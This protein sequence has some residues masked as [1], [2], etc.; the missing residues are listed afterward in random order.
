MQLAHKITELEP[1]KVAPYLATQLRYGHIEAV[2]GLFPGIFEQLPDYRDQLEKVHAAALKKE[3]LLAQTQPTELDVSQTNCPSCGAVLHRARQDA[4]A[5]AC[6][7]CGVRFEIDDPDGTKTKVCDPARNPPR[8]FIRLGMIAKFDG[9]PFQVVGRSKYSGKCREWDS[10]DNTWESTPWHFEEWMLLGDDRS[11]RYLCHDKEGMTLSKEFKPTKP[12]LP[13]PND[14]TMTLI[15]GKSQSKIEEHGSYRLTYFE[16]EF[17]WTPERGEG[18]RTAEYKEKKTLL[19]AEAR[20]N[21]ETGQP[22]EI[23]FFQ[24]R[25]LQVKEVLTAFDRKEELAELK[26][27]EG[28]AAQFRFF[29]RAA[30]LVCIAL[31]VGGFILDSR[32]NQIF[33]QNVNLDQIGPDGLVIGPIQMTREDRVH[34]L[35]LSGSFPNNTWTFVGA[36]LLNEQQDAV[37]AVDG[38]FWHE[39]GYDE[40]HWSETDNNSRRYFRLSEPGRYFVRLSNERGTAS[41]GSVTVVVAEDVV[42]GRYY[43]LPAILAL[44]VF[45]SLIRIMPREDLLKGITKKDRV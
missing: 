11:F 21:S 20:L 18:L 34:R 14:R 15:A 1:Q 5:I 43:F 12:G 42:L 35:E 22:A 13:G 30:L 33:G 44:I 17:G 31:F 3:K 2:L 23:E 38:D 36:E 16:G 26:R 9:H 27:R 41:S 8:S 45:F 29:R 37:N 19:S 24:T 39:S 6:N 10:E 32:G 25:D 40:G 28:I 4:T 7:Y